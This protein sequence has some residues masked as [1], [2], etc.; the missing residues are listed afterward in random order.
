M[1]LSAYHDGQ[2]TAESRKGVTAHLA[3]CSSCAAKL[4]EYEKLSTTFSKLPAASVPS[5]IWEGISKSLDGDGLGLREEEHLRPTNIPPASP[6]SKRQL[7][8]HKLTL[9]ASL[10]LLMGVGIW[11]AGIWL[12]SDSQHSHTHDVHHAE[13]AETMTN[14]LHLLESNPEQAHGFLMQKYGGQVV[15]PEEAIKFVGYRPAINQGLPTGYTLES[16]SV[17]KMPCCTCVKSVCRREDGSTIVLFEH[18]EAE[19]K[20]L[21]DR[22]TQIAMCGDQECCLMS[23]DSS[24][25]ASWKAGSRLLTVI[26]IKDETELSELVSSLTDDS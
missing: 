3:E 24:L 14:Y 6:V 8:S 23:L 1:Q 21:G 16:T 19:L 4:L 9:A 17:L 13:F 20:L 26:G 5:S 25:A 10:V 15:S 7:L 18:D 22:E 12:T 2:L 11:G